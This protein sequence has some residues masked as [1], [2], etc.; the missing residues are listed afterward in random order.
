MEQKD[1]IIE[2][3]E[4]PGQE[5]GQL[6]PGDQEEHLEEAA[7]GEAAKLDEDAF[8]KPDYEKEILGI[9][10]SNATPKVMRDQL[11]EYH[12]ADIAEVLPKLTQTERIK[13][14]RILDND[15]VS[16][17]M[18]YLDEDDA[19]RLLSEMDPRKAAAV[20]TEIEPDSAVVILRSIPKERRTLLIDLLDEESRNDVRLIAS[21]DEDEIGS[22]M[23]T[24]YIVIRENLSVKGAMSELVRQAADND[25]ISTIF[26]VDEFGQFYG[27]IDLKEL[28]IARQDSPLEDLIVTSFP[29]VYGHE[30]IDDCIERLKDYSEDYLP[31]LD[32]VN[33]LI[34]VITSASV[35][36]V[37]DEEFGEDYVKLAGLTA[38][39]DLTEPLLA[40]MR[41]R[42]PW[43]ITLLVL[44]LGV[45]AVVGAYEK[46]V[47]QLTIIMAFQSMIL[48]M[49]GNTG[50]Q[51]LAVTIRVLTDE[52][53]TA[54]QK[55]RFAFKELRVGFTDGCIIG[56]FA[57]I[58]VGLYIIFLKG[59]A[60]HFA[61]LVS[62][63]IGLSMVIAMTISG[64]LGSLIPMVFKKLGI[65][66]A[67]ASG[68]LITTINDFIAVVTYYTLCLVLLL[69]VFH[70]G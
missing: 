63:C 25:N 24:N 67:V 62:G 57:F 70:L 69:G 21:F 42:L 4:K 33:K 15:M 51:S 8:E 54:G 6:A 22:R 32:N 65:D 50:T 37:V 19:G 45:S 26:V 66:P 9:I 43:L 46:V 3:K 39:E 20:I 56:S 7:H 44:G 11:E 1:K 31:V 14:Y 18:E 53:L 5:A 48:D 12:G 52:T 61:F 17:I 29:Y 10:R 60:P 27:A 35:I 64:L 2:E 23:T 49:S 55:A 36:E 59:K 47:A 30:E 58:L 34:G 13:V 41:K 68:P 40:S 38:E 28:I 16:D